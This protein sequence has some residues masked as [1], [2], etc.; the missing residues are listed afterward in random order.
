MTD[1]EEKKFTEIAQRAISEAEKIDCPFAVFV[2]G[3]R[4]M[5]IDIRERHEMAE[6][7]LRGRERE[8]S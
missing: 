2:E 1:A 7:E 4:S 8:G 5:M 3:L 6:D